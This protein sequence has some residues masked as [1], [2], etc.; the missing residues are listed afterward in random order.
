MT[1]K[2]RGLGRGLEALL[3][4]VASKE[5]IHQPQSV[6]PADY[7]PDKGIVKDS[8][9]SAPALSSDSL[10][11]EDNRPGKSELE[12]RQEQQSSVIQGDIT[13]EKQELESN[14][15]QRSVETVSLAAQV[16][17]RAAI[18]VAL[19]KN[20]QKEHLVLLEEAEALKKLIEEFEAMIRAD[21]S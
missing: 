18:V 8:A 10:D 7:Q 21:L 12:S 5:E 15:A 17:D 9:Q 14:Q 16:D 1:V 6:Q 11:T 13:L 20:I 3:V 19:F 2:K 4:D